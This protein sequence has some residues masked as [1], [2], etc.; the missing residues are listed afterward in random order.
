MVHD[1]QAVGHIE[2]HLHVV[3]DH[4]HRAALFALHGADDVDEFTDLPALTGGFVE[5]DDAG[6][7][8]SSSA[9]SSLRLSPGQVSMS[10][11][12][13]W[14]ADQVKTRLISARSRGGA[15]PEAARPQP[16]LDH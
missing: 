9:S 10:A 12:A 16:G 15:L 5:Q 2:Q 14:E 8:A 13:R 6:S 3:F 4:E 11:S 1:G 7:R